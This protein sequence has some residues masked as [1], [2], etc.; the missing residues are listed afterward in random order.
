MASL[1]E[2]MFR[3]G[4]YTAQKY[5][6]THLKSR[7]DDG[8]E[9]RV[10]ATGTP[11]SPVNVFHS[12]FGYFAG[13][14]AVELFSILAILF[15]FYGWWNLGRPMSFSPLEIAKVGY[16]FYSY[17]ACLSADLQLVGL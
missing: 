11:L 7:I 13:A 8:L 5:N 12:D 6:E 10:N 14:A 1:N 3:T 17:Y 15:T 9:I 4:V 16:V 2:I